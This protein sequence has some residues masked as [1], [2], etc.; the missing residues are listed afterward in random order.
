M[1]TPIDRSFWRGK[2]VLVTGHT[3]FKGAWACLLLSRLEARLAGFALP[4]EH[5]SL[6]RQARVRELMEVE[7]LADIRELEPLSSLLATWRPEVIIHFAAQSLVRACHRQPLDS[8]SVNVMGTA[9]LLEAA[10]RAGGV[11][12]VLIATTDKVYYNDEK[13]EPFR[14][15]DRLG[16]LDPYGASKAAAEFAVA[17]YRA[18][19]LEREGIAV[20]VCR[21]GNV[22]GGGDWS[23][24]RLLPDI[25]RAVE[26]GSE[27]VLRNPDSIRPWQYVLDALVGYLMLVERA[28]AFPA[29]R[30][31]P[32]LA[33]WNFGPR[34]EDIH[35]TVEDICRRVLDQW[36]GRLVWKIQHA[37]AGAVNESKIL[38]LNAD[39]ARQTLGW[40]PR[41]DVAGALRRTLEWYAGYFEK[42][43]A[44]DLSYRQIERHLA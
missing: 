18:T 36:P 9:N 7:R 17:A 16:G 11:E 25:V 1:S 20:P 32:E 22:I 31:D 21:A 39:K 42:I 12:T 41:E 26:D 44:R 19:Y 34:Q 4:A 2:R 5:K 38:S 14:E 8:F 13:S 33:A 37:S 35:V 6:Y 15:G 43:D 27:L 3:G 40:E 24:D 23:E 10:R 29:G 30:G 28:A